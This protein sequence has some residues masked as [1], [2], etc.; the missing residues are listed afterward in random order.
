MRVKQIGMAVVGALMAAACAK[1]E[2]PFVAPEVPLAYTR[3]INAIPDS[4]SV[5]F[6]FIDFLE[7]SPY[8]IQLNFRG[9]TPYQGT[10]P[11]SRQLRVFTDPGGSPSLDDVTHILADELIT[12]EA[13][14]YYTIAIVGFAR[15]GSTPGVALQVYEDQI[16]D[17]GS[18]VAFRVVH[19]GSGLNTVNVGVTAASADPIPGTADF[20]NVAYLGASAYATRAT[21]TAWFRVQEAGATAELV[22][23]NGR[24]A[25]AGTVGDPLN[26]LT[27]IGGAA[28]AGS[29]VTAYLFPASV[30]GS[31]APQTT[32]FQ[33][34]A[35]VFVVDKHPR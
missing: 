22:A 11:G 6:R 10:A 35:I 31:T 25:P 33:S 16:P 4:G 2:G 24:Q 27:T 9:F 12:F 5:D 30:T 19:L 21:G 18:N 32:A 34:P 17:A 23:G 20:A 14:K 3:F 29:V 28:Q 7:Y 8:A 15:S 13:N 26:H 1:D